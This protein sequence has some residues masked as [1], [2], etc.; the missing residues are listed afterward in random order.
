MGR[1]LQQLSAVLLLLAA[2]AWWITGR[3]AISHSVRE[4]FL[5]EQESPTQPEASPGEQ[6]KVLLDKIL[7]E[8]PPPPSQHCPEVATL[9]QRLQELQNIPALVAQAVQR[10]RNTPK[11]QT[12]ASWSEAELEAL[13]DYQAKFREAWEPFLSGPTPEWAKYP[14]SAIFFREFPPM[15]DSYR[16]IFHYAFYEAELPQSWGGESENQAEFYLRLF[17]QTTN[18]GTL[19]YGSLSGWG[20]T[21]ATSGVKISEM[22]IRKAGYFFFPRSQSPE[23][24]PLWTPSPPTVATLRE[25]LKTDRAVFLRSAQYLESLPPQTPAKIGLTRLLGDE[26]DASWFVSHVN[27]PKTVRD[28]AT[29]LRQGADQIGSLAQKTYLSGPA[30]R[31]WL[32]GDLGSGMNPSLRGAL[33]GMAEFEQ[34]QMRYQVSLAFLQAS[35]AYRKSGVEGM[36]NIS[37]PA[38]PGSF[39]SVTSSSNG[40]TLS[41]AFLEKEGKNYSFTFEPTP[42]P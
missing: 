37:D 23:E 42:N 8:L 14:D 3:L 26:G 40:I 38:Q 24:L 7:A 19:R 10:D 34:V 1:S 39:L 28:L 12:P 22:M 2:M 29:I 33:E 15:T 41:S 17:R 13:R 30:W 36:Q 35:A 4:F 18:L 11:D 9:I 16:D 27:N 25:G 21:D 5:G 31:H 6:E 32:T 20:M